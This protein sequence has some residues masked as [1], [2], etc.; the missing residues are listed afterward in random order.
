MYSLQHNQRDSRDHLQLTSNSGGVW[1]TWLRL[2][3]LCVGLVIVRSPRCIGA[4]CTG[5]NFRIVVPTVDTLRP[6]SRITTAY[7]VT[8]DQ[9]VACV[10]YD[11]S[12]GL[13]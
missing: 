3:L 9:Q 6:L 7:L 13:G 1:F 4:E 5:V 2:T 8:P 12:T 11:F 10:A